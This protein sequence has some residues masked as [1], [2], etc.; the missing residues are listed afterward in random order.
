MLKDLLQAGRLIPA[1]IIDPDDRL[2]LVNIGHANFGIT[3]QKHRQLHT[4]VIA[5]A[6][7]QK[8]A[9]LAEADR[10]SS[11]LTNQPPH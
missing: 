3:I 2:D 11:N 6:P 5:L 9:P 1:Q 8:V 4:K 7:A 10:R